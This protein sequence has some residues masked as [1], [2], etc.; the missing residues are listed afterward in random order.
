M[1][2]NFF[3]SVFALLAARVALATSTSSTPSSTAPSPTSTS[4]SSSSSDSI[5]SLQIIP[6]T[7][8]IPNASVV[9]L[10]EGKETAGGVYSEEL[11]TTTMSFF[12]SNSYY[13]ISKFY[14]TTPHCKMYHGF[15]V[16]NL[17]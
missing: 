12:W 3:T 7:T 14:T 6:S 8:A 16:V 15:S 17:V 10:Q 13:T 2:L 11:M 9:F 4:S 5:F 1:K